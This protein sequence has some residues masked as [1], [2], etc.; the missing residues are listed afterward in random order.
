MECDYVVE[1]SSISIA[2]IALGFTFWQI[3]ESRKHNRLSVKPHLNI[4]YRSA[5]D[6]KGPCFELTNNGTGPAIIKKF[7]I[8]IEETRFEI[9]AIEDFIEAFKSLNID[10]ELIVLEQLE[11]EDAIY[12]GT[13]SIILKLKNDLRDNESA[14]LEFQKGIM[15]VGF[16]VAYESIYEEE[17]ILKR[18]P[19]V[20][21]KTL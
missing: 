2:V 10:S 8:Y 17:F 5:S 20:G 3:K 21:H 19:F 18:P 9:N 4:S 6:P 1:I 12:A 13:S 14:V 16:E 7:T 11:K 15:Q